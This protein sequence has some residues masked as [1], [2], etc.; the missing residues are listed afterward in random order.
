V[1][2]AP[3]GTA[4]RE[5]PVDSEAVGPRGRTKAVVLTGV[6]AEREEMVE[7]GATAA[8]RAR[9]AQAAPVARERE[10]ASPCR[11][12]V[13]LPLVSR[14]NGITR[15]AVRV[16]PAVGGSWAEPARPVAVVASAGSEEMAE[17][18]RVFRSMAVPGEMVARAEP[19]AS[20]ESEERQRLVAQAVRAVLR[21]EAG[22]M[23]RPACSPSI[24][25]HCQ[26][27]WRRAVQAGWVAWVGK[28]ALI[29][30]VDLVAAAALAGMEALG[31]AAHR[32]LRLAVTAAMAVEG[33]LAEMEEPIR[34]ALPVRPGVLR[35]RVVPAPEAVC[36]SKAD[37]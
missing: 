11:V 30:Q 17:P 34:T 23:L 27:T 4:A 13:L 2:A 21:A 29:Y 14:S 25:A 1:P 28:V 15:S 16:A 9:L 5:V 3:P 12:E 8:Q 33:V 7:P 32:Q 31:S 37:W 26:E 6:T 18:G 10:A 24:T 20:P 19:V 22:P 36:T 35:A